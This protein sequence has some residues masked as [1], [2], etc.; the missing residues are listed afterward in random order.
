MPEPAHGKIFTVNIPLRWA[1]MDAYGHINNVTVFRILEE[2]RVAVLGAPPSAGDLPA[3][4]PPAPLPVFINP[5]PGT[6]ALVAENHAKYLSPLPYRALPVPVDVWISRVRAAS[7]TVSYHISDPHTGTR[8][9][10]AST[11]LAFVNTDGTVV[12]LRAD[13]RARLCRHLLTGS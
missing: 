11:V 1:D 9:V 6:R 5:Q 2:A 7:F 8:C 10:S 12:R 3:N 4:S 13:Q